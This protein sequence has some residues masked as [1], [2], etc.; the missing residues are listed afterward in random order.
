M[1]LNSY[2]NFEKGRI[3]KIEMLENLRDYPRMMTDLYFAAYSDGIITGAD[4][5]VKEDTLVITKGIVKHKG[6]VY[7]LVSDIALPYQATGKETLIKMRFHEKHQQLDFTNHETK[8]ML[9]ENVEIAKNE[10]ELGRFKLKLGAQL[11][12]AYEDFFDFATEY[13]TVNYIHCHYAGFQMSTFHPLP[14]RQFAKELLESE[15]SNAY[16]IAFSL[17]CLNQ[18]RIQREVIAHYLANRLG[19]GYREYTNEQIHQ[20]LGRIIRENKGGSRAMSAQTRR[21]PRRMIVD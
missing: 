19:T 17:Q 2:P 14:L 12:S 11:R 21:G 5:Q 16:D 18:D 1:F 20:Q 10:L 3:L 4:I 9:D 15:L 8:I 6:R 13:N 7:L